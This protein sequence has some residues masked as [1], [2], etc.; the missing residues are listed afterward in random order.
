MFDVGGKV[1]SLW[2]HYYDDLDAIIF[3]V[4]STDKDR[5]SIVKDEFNK[6]SSEISFQSAVILVL[7]NKQD[8]QECIDFKVLVEE[9]G[10][11][12]IN[13][14]D[15]IIQKC[16]AKTGDGLLDGMEKL[17]CYFLKNDKA[18]KTKLTKQANTKLSLVS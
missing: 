18:H 15:I 11:D 4:D 10:I 9:I 17:A 16:S 1:R 8:L 5:I 3:V 13:E 7:F 2:S 12:S 6:L 14:N